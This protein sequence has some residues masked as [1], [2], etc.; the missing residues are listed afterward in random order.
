MRCED[1]EDFV[2]DFWNLVE[3]EKNNVNVADADTED[4]VSAEED[5]DPSSKAI[6][7]KVSDQ[8]SRNLNFRDFIS[9]RPLRV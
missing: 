7:F 2:G 1:T 3:T 4:L 5:S 6:K 9:F 8:E